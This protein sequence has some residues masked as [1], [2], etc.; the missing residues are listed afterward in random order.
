MTGPAGTDLAESGASV[1][2]GNVDSGANLVKTFTIHNN[3]IG[4][5]T[6]LAITMDG[7]DA[8]E[9]TVGLPGTATLESG[10]STT[11]TVTFSPTA[12]GARS[13]VIHIASNDDDENPFDINLIGNGLDPNNVAA[14]IDL[15]GTSI[16]HVRPESVWRKTRRALIG[17][18]RFF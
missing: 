3:G 18:L 9:F 5:L 14:G 10:E 7:T 12:I 16:T 11:F 15:P 1:D 4:D 2:F 6:D 17:R 13:A 8:T